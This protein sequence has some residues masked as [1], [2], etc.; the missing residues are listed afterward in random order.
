M[1]QK[2]GQHHTKPLLSNTAPDTP[3]RHGAAPP[4]YCQQS[5]A[6]QIRA[7]CSAL[8]SAA[9]AGGGMLCVRAVVFLHVGMAVASPSITA[10]LRDLR[11]VLW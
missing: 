4:P 11:H 3:D 8:G 2:A 10:V 1:K 7:P 5:K 9:G 6:Y